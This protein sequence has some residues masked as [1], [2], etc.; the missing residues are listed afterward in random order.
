M[1]PELPGTYIN[2]LVDIVKRWNISGDQL[3]DGSGVTLE[4]LTKPYWYVEFH[5]L[6]KLL[7]HAIE[8][9]H[10]PALAGYL[11]LEM[12][13]S[14]YGSVGIAAMVCANLEEALKTLEQFIGSRC[15]AFKPELKQEQDYI[16]WSIR[17]P[18]KAFRLSPN[19]TIF[20]LLGF[21][22][23]AKHLTGLSSL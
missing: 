23:I 16:Y 21:V 5:T 3:L 7:E 14:C 11:A 9:T 1:N 2:L 10:E 15:D 22:Q 17:Q 18:L 13:A 6:N 12:K 4:Q 20:L 19:A 8:L